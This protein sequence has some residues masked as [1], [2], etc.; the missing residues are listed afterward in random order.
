[1]QRRLLYCPHCQMGFEDFVARCPVCG[2]RWKKNAKRKSATERVRKSISK[3]K[4]ARIYKRDGYKCLHCGSSRNLTLDHIVPISK[5]GGSNE[6]N[7][8][9]LCRRCN[10]TVKRGKST[11][12]VDGIV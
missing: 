9:T 5:H 8:Q 10:C 11:S 6:E 2:T 7:L 4:R 12:Y 3:A 1:M